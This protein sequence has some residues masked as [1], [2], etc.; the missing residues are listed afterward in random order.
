MNTFSKHYTD[1]ELCLLHDTYMEMYDKLMGTPQQWILTASY[2]DLVN[3]LG[4]I[5]PDLH[6]YTM[7]MLVYKQNVY[8]IDGANDKRHEDRLLEKELII[9][10]REDADKGL[11]KHGGE[12]VV[13]RDIMDKFN[14]SVEM[15]DAYLLQAF[16]TCYIHNGEQWLVKK[17]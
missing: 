8:E 12:L 15:T 11:L 3:S 7:F 4:N 2:S 17:P 1:H 14:W 13:P 6:K 5:H 16:G 9:K 10:I